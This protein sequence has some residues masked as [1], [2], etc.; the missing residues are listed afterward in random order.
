MCEISK[1]QTIGVNKPNSAI[2]GEKTDQTVLQHHESDHIPA[3][4]DLEKEVHALR[5]TTQTQR[6]QIHSLTARNAK[7]ESDRLMVQCFAVQSGTCRDLRDFE[8]SFGHKPNWQQLWND[9]FAA[10]AQ[11]QLNSRATDPKERTQTKIDVTVF[12]LYSLS[13]DVIQQYGTAEIIGSLSELA[14]FYQESYD[15][16]TERGEAKE[17]WQQDDI[18][19]KT[20]VAFGLVKYFAL[21]A[22]KLRIIERYDS[23]LQSK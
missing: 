19:A 7:L 18:R 4:S 15:S 22:E 17:C 2:E 13:S 8:S 10:L 1:S 11:D 6:D 12:E 20:T 23:L 21:V 3:K 14:I 16:E 9:K 5:L